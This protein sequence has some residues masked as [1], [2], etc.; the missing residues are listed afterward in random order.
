[1]TRA[2]A[3]AFR[4]QMRM[5]VVQAWGS[6]LLPFFLSA[7]VLGAGVCLTARLSDAGAVASR[8]ELLWGQ[9]T[10][11]FRDTPREAVRAVYAT[12]ASW[13]QTIGLLVLLMGTTG[14]LPTSLEPSA[15]AV[16]LSKPPPRWSLLAGRFL[17]IVALAAV[18]G[19]MFVGGTWLALGLRVQ[20]WEPTYLLSGPWLVL[21]FAAVASFAA[22][23]AVYTRSAAV[24]IFGSAAFWLLCLGMNVGRHAVH[25]TASLEGMPASFHFLVEAG[26]WMLPK[27]ADST[28]L[29]LDALQAGPWVPG[30][31]D[32]RALVEA[33]LLLPGP[34]IA[35]E[36][37]FALVM[38]VL[39]AYEF[40]TTDY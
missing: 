39:A 33:G 1:M 29:M 25:T 32:G 16:L 22:I 28:L 10:L 18:W 27:P 14:Y 37:L 4:W 34:I 30:I 15:A 40:A 13:G 35:S 36:L 12:L 23:L 38:L 3:I 24:C 19:L 6:S 8:V 7:A 5:A 11:P 2:A 20:V 17:G 31:L 9:W 26:Y 21:D